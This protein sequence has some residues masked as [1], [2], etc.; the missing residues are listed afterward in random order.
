MQMSGNSASLQNS[1]GETKKAVLETAFFVYLRWESNPNLKFRKLPF[2]PLNYR[3]KQV[4]THSAAK[5][6]LF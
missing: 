5:I 1:K 3:G 4:S 2:Y 6:L